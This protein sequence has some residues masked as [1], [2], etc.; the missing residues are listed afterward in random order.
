[1][2]SVKANAFPIECPLCR[3]DVSGDLDRHLATFHTKEELV[4]SVVTS[5]KEKLGE[6]GIL[7]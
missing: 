6:D 7:A 5:H 1:M 4:E 2:I 3:R